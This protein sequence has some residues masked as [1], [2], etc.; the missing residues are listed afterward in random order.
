MLAVEQVNAKGGIKSLGGAPLEV[1]FGD[2]HSTPASAGSE[3][4]R[5]IDQSGVVMLAGAS[6]SA[7]TIPLS[8]AAERKGL[9][10]MVINGQSEEITNR[11]FKWLWSLG[12]QDKDFTSAAIAGL[13]IAQKAIP[14][15]KRVA[16]AYGDN[17]TGQAAGRAFRELMKAEKT[18]EIVGDVEYSARAQ[19]FGPTVLK[20]KSTG[21][22]MV[23]LNGALREVVAFSRAFDQYDYHPML[24]TLGGGTADPKY[25]A[26][27]GK[28][29]NGVFN[30][31]SFAVDLPRVQA[32]T[33]AYLEK[34]KTPMST[35]AAQGYQTLRTLADIL[36]LAADTKPGAIAAAI[37]AIKVPG[38]QLTTSSSFIEFEG[39]L[40]K[41]RRALLTQWQ[42]GK[43][44]TVWPADVAV[45]AAV[46][47]PV[48]TRN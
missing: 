1:V 34:Y 6:S 38:D 8:V 5:L 7:E 29:A 39:P 9:P 24:V 25:G 4:D 47:P 3:G 28:S 43:L 27:V 14:E 44:V 41:G 21:A 22:Q 19:D 32:V 20:I 46:A 23:V 12:V 31:T 15:L 2:S 17:E 30:A 33:A 36:E 37:K 18:F 45:G 48:N 16:M 13:R 42:D 11:G 35:N 10:M 26:Q 40:N